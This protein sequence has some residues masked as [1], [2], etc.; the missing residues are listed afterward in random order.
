MIVDTHPEFGIELVL[1]TPY[2]Y[3]LHTQGQLDTVYTTKGMKPFYYFCDNVIEKYEHRTIDNKEANMPSLP[4]GWLHHNADAVMG[5][6]YSLLSNE[7]K[8][9]VNGV[10][11]YSEWTSP[12]FETI[13]KNDRFV[14]DK[15][16]VVINNC[17]NVESNTKPTRYFS[18]ECLYEMFSCLTEKGYLVIYHRPKNKELPAQDQNER[19]S[20]GLGDIEASVDGLGVINDY[21]LTEHFDDVMLFSDLC[22]SNLDLSFNEIQCMLYA[23]C[24][25]FI[26]Y[27]G[28]AGI[29]ASYFGGTNIMWLSRGGES[30]ENYFSPDSYYKKLSSCNIITVLDKQKTYPHQIENY[31]ELLDMIKETY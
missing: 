9:Q 16:I 25:K 2:A 17:F 21:Q 15:P 10:L 22:K 8:A 14:F 27:V 20:D 5:K 24:D 30:R 31:K 18:I 12:P 29:L 23:N 7:E 13:Y 26:S 19:N 6:D 4:N 3:W 11:D 28:G 1:T